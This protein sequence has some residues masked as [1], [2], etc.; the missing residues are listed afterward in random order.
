VPALSCADALTG[1]GP[2]QRCANQKKKRM[3]DAQA[4]VVSIAPFAE[5]YGDCAGVSLDRQV[6]M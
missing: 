5:R 2:E 6:C 3:R 4:T 1:R